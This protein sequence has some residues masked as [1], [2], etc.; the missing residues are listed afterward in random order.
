MEWE[1]SAHGMGI[2]LVYLLLIVFIG[3]GVVYGVFGFK[4]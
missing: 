3:E 1:F 2:V 4:I